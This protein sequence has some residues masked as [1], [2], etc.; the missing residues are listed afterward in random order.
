MGPLWTL[1]LGQSSAAPFLLT[2]ADILTA[3]LQLTCP[4]GPDSLTRSRGH[5][6][7]SQA[8]HPLL[9]SH[10]SDPHVY[11]CATDSRAEMRFL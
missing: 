1:T 11:L 4:R 10:V 8:P 3:H 6:K 9:L 2:Q 7:N 5:D